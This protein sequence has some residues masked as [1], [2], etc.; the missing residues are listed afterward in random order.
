MV[1]QAVKELPNE[2]CGFLAGRVAQ[3]LADQTSGPCLGHV[4]ERFPLVNEAASP[5]EYHSSQ[6]N[7]EAHREIRKHGLDILAVYH[8]HPTTD[9]VPSRKDLDQ[10]GW[11]SELIHLII[12]LKG[13]EPLVR[14]WHLF[15]SEYREADWR[16]V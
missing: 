7:F 13:D 15:E 2:C 8:S 3:D 16:I 10:N 5:V 9:P 14:G 12:S 4:V 6:A 1:A 11:G